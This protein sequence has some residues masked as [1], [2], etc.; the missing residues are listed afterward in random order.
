VSRVPGTGG[1]LTLLATTMASLTNPVWATGT[2]IVAN[3]TEPRF[4]LT[5]VNALTGRAIIIPGGSG[6]R[7]LGVLRR[8]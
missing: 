2:M 7:V 6:W 8:S 5:L 3:L 4:A 1:N